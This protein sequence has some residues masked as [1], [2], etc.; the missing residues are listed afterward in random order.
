MK[1]RHGKDTIMINHED[2][3]SHEPKNDHTNESCTTE[4]IDKALYERTVAEYTEQI[5]AL[6]DKYARLFADIE[7]MK[8]RAIEEQKLASERIEKKIFLSILPIIDNFERAMQANSTAPAAQESGFDLIYSLFQTLLK[9]HGI[10]EIET[11]GLFNPEIHEA[12]SQISDTEKE[13]GTIGQVFE[14]GYYLHNKVLRPAKV[15]V[16]G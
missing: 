2:H 8:R 15:A 9:Q 4:T 6:Q 11:N 14:K 1:Y 10:R 5:A 16:V 13:S 7:N 12:I 3:S